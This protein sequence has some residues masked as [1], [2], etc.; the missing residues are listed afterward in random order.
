MMR[1]RRSGA[2]RL[3]LVGVWWENWCDAEI[4]ASHRKA[5]SDEPAHFAP[6]PASHNFG[7]A[8]APRL[9]AAM[10]RDAIEPRARRAL[11]TE[12]AMT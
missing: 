7:D 6:G 12:G 2:R 8:Q 10:D 11:S 3:P 5:P 4:T 1:R 9:R